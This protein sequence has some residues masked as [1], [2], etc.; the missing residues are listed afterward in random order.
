METFKRRIAAP[1]SL[2]FLFAAIAASCGGAGGAGTGTPTPT[3]LLSDDFSGPLAAKWTIISGAGS[4]IASTA[5]SGDAD[6]PGSP[7]HGNPSPGLWMKGAAFG[8]APGGGGGV[9]SINTYP[10][11]GGLTVSVDGR[12]DSGLEPF[13]GNGLTASL[14]DISGGQPLALVRVNS[15]SVTYLLTIFDPTSGNHSQEVTHSFP[16]D[17]GFRRFAFSIDASGNAQWSRDG[18]LQQTVAG[19]PL[20]KNLSLQATSPGSTDTDP[21]SAH[22]DNVQVTTP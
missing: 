22:M 9:R 20:K 21:G 11:S 8:T 1:G 10:T 12:R 19:F 18:A 4:S 15:G 6:T 3:T 2:A 5:T 16:P 7:P 17:S 14:T 13:A